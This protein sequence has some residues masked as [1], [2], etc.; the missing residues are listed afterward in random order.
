MAKIIFDRPNKAWKVKFKADKGW[1]AKTLCKGEY[2]KPTPDYVIALAEAILKPAD[3]TPVKA[4]KG[5]NLREWFDIYNRRHPS[6]K[7]N[8][9]R[10]RVSL[11]RRFGEW[12]ES[13]GRT[14]LEDIRVADI[15]AWVDQRQG[16]EGAGH[17]TI[18]ADLACLQGVF[19]TAIDEERIA[20]NP[21]TIPAKNARS[22][23]QA[24]KDN[25]ED[26]EIKYYTRDQQ[27]RIMRL[28]PRM[29]VHW[30]E[31]IRVMLH[32]GLRVEAASQIEAG[33]LQPNHDL[34]IPK[35]WD[36][37]KTGYTTHVF[38]SEAK[39]IIAQRIAAHPT[40][41]IFPEVTTGRS[42]HFF[43][44]FYSRYGGYE[45][46]IAIGSYNHTFRHTFAV[47]NVEAGMPIP[48]LQKLLG[49]RNIRTTMIYAKVSDVAMTNAIREIEEVYATV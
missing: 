24:A 40:G 32:T 4:G 46:I 8:G 13:Q 33:W 26:E 44:E 18:V 49:H 7:E 15:N 14:V 2:A 17:S 45:D 20:K 25:A 21:V 28:V 36:K 29:P 19:R 37:A 30:G 1:K 6:V 35:R 39:D 5:T 34:R 3:A 10:R 16:V 38:G 27:A 43:D 22:R 23:A 41:R 9:I 48:I 42:W 47:R 11:L 12:A 31:L